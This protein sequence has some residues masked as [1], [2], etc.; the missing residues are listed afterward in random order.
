LTIK[1]ISIKKLLTAALP[2][3]III[4][5]SIFFD[6]IY[7]S[8]INN[9]S[10]GSG[11]ILNNEINAINLWWYPIAAFIVFVYFLYKAF[12]AVS[13]K[14]EKRECSETEMVKTIE[15]WSGLVDGVGTALPLIGAAVILFTIG[16]GKENQKLFLELAVPFEIKSLFILASAKLFESVFDE[17]EIQVQSLYDQSNGKSE[18]N[19]MLMN[20]KIEF[21]NLPT[22]Y[23]LDEMNKTIAAW[24]E[25]VDSMKDPQFNESLNKII[26]ITGK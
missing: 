2:S 24:K 21:I 17:F 12:N 1:G 7:Q 8:A 13:G 26:K 9:L 15:K 18:D 23:Q 11:I 22:E 10:S 6:S 16:L 5:V 4:I 3:I 20:G 19:S 14:I 25:T